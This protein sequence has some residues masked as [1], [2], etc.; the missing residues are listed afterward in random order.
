MYP[1]AG[2][3]VGGAGDYYPEPSF[4]SNIG[5]HLE[6]M[7]PLVL[8]LIIVFFLAIKFDFITNQ[9]PVIGSVANVLGTGGKPSEILIIGDSS[10]ELL[11]VLN[12]NK[13]LVNY[14]IRTPSSLER[15]PRE[16]LANYDVLILDQ[17]LQEEK[18]VSRELGDAIVNFVKTGGKLVTVMNSGIYRKGTPD[19]V[20]WKAT[21]GDIIP[22]D[23]EKIYKGSPSCVRYVDVRGRI[24]RL[25]EKHKV[26]EGI[27]EFP[28]DR[29]LPPILVRTLE[30]TPLG[31]EVAYIQ[32]EFERGQ[33]VTAIV[34][35]PLIVGKSVYFNYNPGLTPGIFENTLKYLR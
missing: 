32:D 19:V 30:V 4:R 7:I 3:D 14:R 35:K 5:Y 27:D 12:N 2:G 9:T 16:Q 1:E 21:F 23:C 13:D 25:N 33:T 15:N 29:N 20:G 34:E 24:L 28:V 31:T 26:M 6:G 18:A 22:V 10:P 8:I 17:S 11:A